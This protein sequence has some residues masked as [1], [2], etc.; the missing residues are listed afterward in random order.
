MFLHWSS[1]TS[2]S[3][4]W[5]LINYFYDNNQNLAVDVSGNLKSFVGVVRFGSNFVA[6]Y[7]DGKIYYSSN[8]NSWT[9]VDTGITAIDRIFVGNGVVAVEYTNTL[10][11][12]L[13]YSSDLTTWT[14]ASNTSQLETFYVNGQYWRWDSGGYNYSTDLNTWTSGSN[15]NDM[16]TYPVEVLYAN[17]LYVAIAH[18]KMWSSTNGEDWTDRTPVSNP[19]NGTQGSSGNESL[20]YGG[21][22]WIVVGEYFSGITGYYRSTNG[23]T[24]SYV[25]DSTAGPA[26]YG[27]TG[28]P[29]VIYAGTNFYAFNEVDDIA[30]SSTGASGSWSVVE[31]TDVPG[32]GW[33][34]GGDPPTISAA[35]DGTQLIG[36]GGSG[37]IARYV[38]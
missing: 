36:V 10:S 34:V 12:E 7:E 19:P 37:L 35:T 22:V 8:G 4:V 2:T 6:G 20:A 18:N 27:A 33:D 17:S 30:V 13:K 5:E 14:S 11:P 1:G 31:L 26:L 38:L 23:T 32:I 16:D 15:G 9:E 24:W 3:T 28:T 29:E 25:N 21:G